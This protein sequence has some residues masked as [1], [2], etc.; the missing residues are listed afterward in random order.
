MRIDGSRIEEAIENRF[1]TDK[2][3]ADDSRQVLE[4]VEMAGSLTFVC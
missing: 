3:W 2:S 1:G 4:F